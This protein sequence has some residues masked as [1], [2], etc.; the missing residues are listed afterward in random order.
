LAQHTI[1]PV[2]TG[3]LVKHPIPPV[4]WASKVKAKLI[5]GFDIDPAAIRKDGN[6]EKSDRVRPFAVDDRQLQIAV[7]PFHDG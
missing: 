5:V 6:T 1:E 7:G 4:R 2:H 3:C